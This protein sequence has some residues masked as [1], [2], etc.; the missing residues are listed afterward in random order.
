M[1]AGDDNINLLPDD[2]RDQEAKLS[3]VKNGNVPVTFHIPQNPDRTVL[4]AAPKSPAAD[5]LA[6][7]LGE[8][9]SG[10]PQVKSMAPAV[11]P[12]I[13]TPKLKKGP[14]FLSKLFARSAKKSSASVLPL[15]KPVGGDQPKDGHRAAEALAPSLASGEGNNVE[16]GQGQSYINAEMDVNLIPEGTYL[17]PNSKIFKSFIV[18]LIISLAI[19]ALPYV[20]LMVYQDILKGQSERLAMELQQSETAAQQ[21]KAL[22][23]EAAVLVDK[24]DAAKAIID[25]HV[26]WTKVFGLLESLTI[27]DVY[28]KNIAASENGR[29]TLS[30]TGTSYTAVAKQYLVFQQSNLIKNVT[31]LGG[32]GDSTQGEISFNI[33]L[34]LFPDIFY[35]LAAD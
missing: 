32:S 35:S 30:A 16:P 14:G 33:I 3:S 5:N 21:Y 11:Q 23:A 4:A 1:S 26:Y 24:V 17:L 31:I 8:N 28:Y 22:E 27:S 25:R 9:K 19:G 18:P 12:K 15:V 20:G 7:P 34:E 6:R 13:K 29:I 10:L 2:L